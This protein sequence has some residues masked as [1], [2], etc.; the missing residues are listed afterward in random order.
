MVTSGT[1]GV[2]NGFREFMLIGSSM[3]FDQCRA[4]GR[5][6]I[7]D[8]G[9]PMVACDPNVIRAPVPQMNLTTR[10]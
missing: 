5:L 10:Q 4:L 7:H 1:S 3:T 6:I 8:S 9:S 2:G